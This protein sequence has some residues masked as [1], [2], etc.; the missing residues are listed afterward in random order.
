MFRNERRARVLEET[1]ERE[2]PTET[3]KK[4]QR[5]TRKKGTKREGRGSTKDMQEFG[6]RPSLDNRENLMAAKALGPEGGRS[7]R[8]V[9]LP[10]ILSPRCESAFHRIV[11]IS[12][13]TFS[14]PLSVLP[15]HPPNQEK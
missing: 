11:C 4:G 3:M 12:L 5:E 13:L 2:R 14:H 7:M 15:L 8:G 1:K 6:R 10:D 9:S